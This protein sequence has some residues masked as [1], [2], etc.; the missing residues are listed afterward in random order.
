M[1]VQAVGLPQPLTVRN[2]KRRVVARQEFDRHEDQLRAADVLDRVN[3]ILALSVPKMTRLTRVVM[4][5]DDA[6]VFVVTAGD[7]SAKTSPE[8]VQDVAMKCQ[9]AAGRHMEMPNTAALS[10][11][12]G[13]PDNM[14]VVEKPYR[15]EDLARK[16][17][18][19][20]GG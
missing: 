3:E 16:L 15:R 6:A 2:L 4:N 1:L 10:L 19:V 9:E 20:I 11:G 7:P 5:V 8:I 12:H 13:L 14:N 17:R 18:L